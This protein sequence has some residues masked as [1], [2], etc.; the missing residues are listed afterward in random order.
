MT[1]EIK[2][3]KIQTAV[4][5]MKYSKVGLLGLDV[6]QSNLGT[7]KR[8]YKYFLV[9]TK[10]C[11][12]R[13]KFCK[14]WQEQPKNEL[15]IEEYEK[16]AKHSKFL[17][18]LNISGGEPTL[19]EDLFDIIRVFVKHCPHLSMVNFTTNGIK[20]EKII[21]DAKKISDLRLNKVVIN[22]SLDGT[23]KFTKKCAG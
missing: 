19:R 15:T 4:L 3:S 10:N 2:Y 17:K 13:C 9:V 18:W 12:S 8:P 7:L 23:K 14:I 6:L 22:V 1:F 11:N 16:L 20:P 21:S 5:Q